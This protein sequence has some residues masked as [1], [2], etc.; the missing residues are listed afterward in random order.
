[1]NTQ[2]S[3][4]RK[5]QLKPAGRFCSV[6][7]ILLLL[8]TA[9]AAIETPAPELTPTP[10]EPPPTTTP[11][12]TPTLPPTPTATEVAELSSAAT[13]SPTPIGD[14]RTPHPPAFSREGDTLSITP[15]ATPQSTPHEA[16]ISVPCT[17]NT[18]SLNVREGP[19]TNYAPISI[20]PAAAPVTAYK[21]ASGAPWLLV[22]TSE[23][24]VGWVN[25]ALLTC[26]GDIT[27][28]PLAQ[29]VAVQESAAPAAAVQAT[30]PAAGTPA[31]A[32]SPT[33]TPIAPSTAL[34]GVDT[35]RG[36]YFSNPSLAGEP[37]LLHEEPTLDLNW[38]LD[39]P[40]PGIPNDNFSVRWTRQLNF[41]GGDYRFFAEADDGIRVYLDGNM[42]IDEWHEFVPV[43]YSGDVAGLPAGPH[44]LKVEYYESGSLARV[45]VWYEKVT[46][47]GDAW[48]GEYFNNPKWEGSPFTVRQDQEIDFDWN[49]DSPISGMPADDFSIRWRRTL[50]FED[51]D[52][53][54]FADVEEKD[55]VKI[56]LDGWVVVDKYTE[57]SARL[58]GSFSKLGRGQHTITV[59]YWDDSRDAEINFGWEKTN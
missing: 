9:C 42:I 16:A 18:G 58:E 46:F 15:T 24:Q 21:C 49:K 32:L 51:G 52:Y 54:F 39:S 45:K 47:A 3:Q 20:L 29:G 27:T 11:V 8:T 6:L 56:Y 10:T 17:V 14:R 25:A 48:E 19:G 37:L 36:E 38:V 55:G 50:Y 43:T 5:V 44:T 40:L 34:A 33:T 12:P 4:Q 28:L 59:E 30:S 13:P 2:L 26:Q 31:P 41:E 35:W 7:I 57:E 53:R 22:E 23:N 1:M